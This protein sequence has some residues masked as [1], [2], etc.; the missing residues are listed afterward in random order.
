M[1]RLFF[2][3]DPMHHVS[4]DLCETAFVERFRGLIRG[5]SFGTFQQFE[6]VSVLATSLFGR[7]QVPRKRMKTSD[8]RKHVRPTRIET[9]DVLFRIRFSTT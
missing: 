3:S 9:I 2:N 4:I 6:M 7:F 8:L 1:I 5:A